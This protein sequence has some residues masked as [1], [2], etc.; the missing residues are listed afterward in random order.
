MAAFVRRFV[1]GFQML[2]SIVGL[3]VTTLGAFTTSGPSAVS[4]LV[5][6]AAVGFFG[7][8]GVAGFLLCRGE[9]L[10][11]R[12]SLVAKVAEVVL[13]TKTLLT[14]RAKTPDLTHTSSC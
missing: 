12:L 13:L 11:L 1:A 4:L 8:P 7:A 5:S 2:G 14:Y 10:A 9:A 6:L 3:G